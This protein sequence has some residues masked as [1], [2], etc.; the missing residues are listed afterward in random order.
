[1][2]VGF[3]VG[4]IESATQ[5]VL[6]RARSG[7]GGYSCLAGVH[8]VVHAYHAPDLRVALDGAWVNFADG[9][10]VAWLLRRCGWAN[11]RRVAGPDLMSAVIEA[12]QPLGLRHFLFGSS[13]DT[14]GR[15]ETNLRRS[16]PDV[17]IAGSL[18]P[19]FRPV[20]S[21]EEEAIAAI[22]RASNPHIAWVALGCPKQDEWMHRNSEKLGPVLS[23][24]VGA[25]FDFLAGTKPRAPLW[26]RTH[27]LEWLHRLRSEPRRLA[28][29]YLTTN[30]EFIARASIEVLRGGQRAHSD[31]SPR[32]A[33]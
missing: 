14:L 10:P 6:A 11:S 26:M 20:S 19:P 15:L 24:G 13:P 4:D 5:V 17:Q 22:I 18:S 25:A 2:D 27:G 3:Y 31:V 12:G 28:Y 1:M 32:K 9:A 29:R 30:S 7:M 21:V 33:R 23:L 16:Y 8:G